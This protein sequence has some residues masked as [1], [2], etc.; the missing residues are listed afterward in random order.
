MMNN[1]IK[2]SVLSL[3]LLFICSHAISQITWNFT[4]AAASSGTVANITAGAVTQAN[5]NGSTTFIGAGSPASTSYANVSGGNNGSVSAKTGA[6]N[7]GTSSYIQVVLTP[8]SGYAV[9]VTGITL[10]SYSVSTSGPTLLSVYT[11][12]DNYTSALGTVS[13]TQNSTWA[14]VSPSF[15]PTNGRKNEAV[16][17]RIYASGGTGGSPAAGTANWRVDDLKVS[18]TPLPVVESIFVSMKHSSSTAASQPWNNIT[19][20]NTLVLN[21]D[22][23]VATTVGLEFPGSSWSNTG[24]QGNVTGNNS[25]VYPDNV[26]RDYHW[27]G[28]YG[29][30]ETLNMFIKGLDKNYLYNIQIFGSSK[31]NAVPDN[32]TTVYAIDGVQKPLNVH[33]NSQNVVNF[34]GIAPNAAGNIVVNMSKG[35]GAPYGLISAFVVEKMLNINAVKSWDY[36]GNAV[37]AVKKL[38]TTDNFDLPI[39]TNNVERMRIGAAGQVGIGT[40]NIADANYKLFVE[41]GIRT[42]KVKVDVVAWPDYVF[43][44]TYKLLPLA[45]VE[46]YIKQHGHLPGI[47]PANEAEKNGIDLGETHAS[48]LKKME[49]MMLYI[50]QLNQKMEA[51]E[52]E[53]QQ[54]KKTIPV[55]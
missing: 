54:L 25:G 50:L 1:V 41:T 9:Q 19:N 26:I 35:P 42:R 14:L 55:Q 15:S 28:N 39:I 34:Q 10:G 40:A 24:D 53:N 38:G 30:P 27:F 45:E 7:T 18:A 5:N 23:W 2:Q 44:S 31:W 17:I 49:E 43:D 8:A 37:A 33:Q 4:S 29:G 6:V 16:T 21:N 52:K 36:N 13:V 48:L 20:I 3:L 46:N 51:L 47:V 22:A 32:G 12:V 11:S